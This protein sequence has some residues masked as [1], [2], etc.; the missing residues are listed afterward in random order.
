MMSVRF[1]YL[2]AAPAWLA[3]LGLSLLIPIYASWGWFQDH[4]LV[5][6]AAAILSVIYGYLIYWLVNRPLTVEVAPASDGGRQMRWLLILAVIGVVLRVVYFW[7]VPPWDRISD[8]G[9]Y[10]DAAQR[11]LDTGRYFYP[12]GPDIELV[13][14]RPPG[15]PFLL[16]GVISWFGDHQ[17][18]YLILHCVFFVITLAMLMDLGR[19]YAGAYG[20]RAVGVLFVLWPSL[21]MLSGQALTE[22]VSLLLFTAI[23]WTYL[24]AEDARGFSW[25][26]PLAGVL[27]GLMILVK[28]S[29]MLF[30][31]ALL[32]YVVLR[33]LKGESASLVRVVALVCVAAVV[34]VPWSIRNYLQ[35]GEII[36]VSSNGG[37]V[38]YRANNP[39][40]SGGFTPQGERDL[41]PYLGNEAEWNRMGFRWGKEWIRD[42]PMQF[43]K[44]ILYKQQIFLGSDQA[45]AYYTFARFVDADTAGDAT[46][47]VKYLLLVASEL[48]WFV[49]WAMVAASL[50][51]HRRDWLTRPD[52]NLLLWLPLYL[53]AIHSVFESQP[54]YHFPFVGVLCLIAVMVLDARRGQPER[55]VAAKGRAAI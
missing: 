21:T 48:W 4:T 34:V 10:I 23:L 52:M 9:A 47:I 1:G 42:N 43:L 50:I 35:T 45:G 16:A 53:I 13:A 29:M 25:W 7:L 51:R 20:A 18:N 6:V 3:L 46:V 24:K 15:Y 44:L 2:V 55:S 30:V 41:N 32:P 33:A 22:P 49:L 27:L 28:S 39:K 40:A 36:A 31:T 5:L 37:S 26:L 14:F 11:L 38:F 54:R 19:R 8:E 12:M 17:V